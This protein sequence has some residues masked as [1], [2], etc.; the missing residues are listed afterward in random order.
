MKKDRNLEMRKEVESFIPD[1]VFLTRVSND[2]GE[3]GMY[4][5]MG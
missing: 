4:F 3:V 5:R 2:I 1:E